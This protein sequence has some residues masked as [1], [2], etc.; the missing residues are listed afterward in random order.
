MVVRL[1]TVSPGRSNLRRKSD[2]GSNAAR[3][4]LI[5][6][7][8]CIFT[9]AWGAAKRR[10]LEIVLAAVADLLLHTSLGAENRVAHQ[11]A[12]S[13]TRQ[14]FSSLFVCFVILSSREGESKSVWEGHTGLNAV[15]LVFPS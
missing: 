10:L 8:G 12:E 9:G 14:Y 1:Y 6:E 11:H 13:L 7:R 3:T 15:T 4:G 5:G 2:G